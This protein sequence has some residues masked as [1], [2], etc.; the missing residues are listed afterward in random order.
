[1]KAILTTLL[2]IFLSAMAFVACDSAVEDNRT[3]AGVMTDAQLE[4]AIEAKINSDAQ[5]NRAGLSVSADADRNEATLSGTVETQDM[6]TKAVELAKSAHSGLII[7][8]KIDVEPKEI[9][10]EGY[11]EE[12][13]DK[14]REKARG[15]GDN[16]GDSLDDAWIHT[17]I[18]AKLIGNEDTPKRKI[19]VDVNNNVVTLRGTVETSE[20]KMEAE[21]V[22]KDTEGVSRVVNQIKVDRSMKSA[23]S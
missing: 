11:T 6:R 19:N 10:R 22:A 14:Q 12:M 9:S 16:V 15:W 21:R 5:L 17:K 8:D 1:M 23:S 3:G 20:E 2:M 4:D 7:T 18:V 13:A